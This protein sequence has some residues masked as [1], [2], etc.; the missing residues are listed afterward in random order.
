MVTLSALTADGQYRDDIAP[1]LRVTAPDRAA[2]VT[3]L[4]QIG[5][6]KYQARIALQASTA[7]AY[8]FELVDTPGLTPQAL[9][10]AGT[11]SLFYGYSDEYRI[12]PK[13]IELLKALC[14]RTGGKFA[15][16]VE[17]IFARHGDG[18][19]V[20]KPLW[21]YFAAVGLVFFLLD[22]LVRRWAG[23]G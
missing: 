4:R 17:E 21:S 23:R 12:L 22:I 5:P 15:P 13:N 18:G 2:G 20:S 7:G 8:A 6:G 16:K 1:K 14:E 19:L 3:P 11:R 10:Q 9:M